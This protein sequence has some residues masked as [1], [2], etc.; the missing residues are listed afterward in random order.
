MRPIILIVFFFF[1]STGQ[2]I[3]ETKDK[4]LL[5]LSNDIAG[6]WR[7]H[8]TNVDVPIKGKCWGKKYAA[9]RGSLT[10]FA[11][12]L[13]LINWLDSGNRKTAQTR[14]EVSYSLSLIGLKNKMV[15]NQYELVD[16]KKSNTYWTD[17]IYRNSEGHAVNLK[18]LRPEDLQLYRDAVSGHLRSLI[19]SAIEDCPL[20]EDIPT[21]PLFLLAYITLP[22]LNNDKA[23]ELVDA[24]IRTWN[25]NSRKDHPKI[26]DKW[27][28]YVAR[29]V[30][31]FDDQKTE[32]LLEN[33]TD[34]VRDELAA[35][36]LK[37]VERIT[38]NN[39]I[40]AYTKV[41][42]L[43]WY[44]S[45]AF[46]MLPID[47]G[48]YKQFIVPPGKDPLINLTIPVAVELLVLAKR[49]DERGSSFEAANIMSI[50]L[51]WETG[52][53]ETGLHL[54]YPIN[55]KN[56]IKTPYPIW[57]SLVPAYQE[58]VGQMQQQGNQL[59]AEQY[60]TVRMFSRSQYVSG[61]AE[62]GFWTNFENVV[63]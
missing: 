52:T 15:N 22:Y 38:N 8:T 59:T 32:L 1:V 60:K 14:Y 30:S 24:T 57:L 41:I 19:N 62:E 5:I 37:Q 2:A 27:L 50:L 28:T 54:T 56:R 13:G 45:L 16:R 36:A 20:D 17:L 46:A 26:A 9:L 40:S 11:F 47:L 58:L 42:R 12:E 29:L 25:N 43:W 33:L 44:Q 53:A 3:S 61:I 18:S 23:V 49:L 55:S 63:N 21:R 6:H 48:R 39:K 7:T 34:N 31:R 10:E 4:K 51:S 35:A